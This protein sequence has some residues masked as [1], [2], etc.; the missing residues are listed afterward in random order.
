MP[1]TEIEPVYRSRFQETHWSLV[2]RAKRADVTGANALEKLC[3]AYRLPLYSFARHRGFSAADAEDLVQD[4]LIQ[5]IHHNHLQSVDPAKG[6]F[7]SFL[8]SAFKNFLANDWDSRRA[9]KRGGSF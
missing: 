6:R 7:R 3:Q 8:I 9:L 2:L 1:S 5:L 4:F